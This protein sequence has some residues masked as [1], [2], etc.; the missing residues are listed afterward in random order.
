MVFWDE[1][2]FGG[3]PSGPTVTTIA[4][5]NILWVITMWT[6]AEAKTNH[7]TC[8]NGWEPLYAIPEWSSYD[9]D[10]SC[11]RQS[12][13]EVSVWVPDH[14][15]KSL[16]IEQVLDEIKKSPRSW[17]DKMLLRVRS[18]RWRNKDTWWKHVLYMCSPKAISI[19]KWLILDIPKV[20]LFCQ[21]LQHKTLAVIE[22][23]E[24]QH[25]PGKASWGSKWEDSQKS[26]ESAEDWRGLHQCNIMQKT[27]MALQRWHTARL[28]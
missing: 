11:G 18:N 14:C 8:M 1:W 21:W 12:V 10:S 24:G 25:L 13:W 17:E 4:D 19:S 16:H 2:I 23:T 6:S 15:P 5:E 26:S 9:I 20:D 3:S 27:G 22:V 7:K 28:T